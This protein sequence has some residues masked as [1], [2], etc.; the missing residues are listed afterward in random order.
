MNLNKSCIEI[1]NAAID[2]LDR[3]TMNLNKSCIEIILIWEKYNGPVPMNLNKSCIEMDS[4]IGNGT[5][6]LG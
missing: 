2:L 5:A 4:I 1:L 3:T 6:Q